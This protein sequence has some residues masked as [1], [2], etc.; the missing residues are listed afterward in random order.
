[1]MRLDSQ[2]PGDAPA[3]A[4]NLHKNVLLLDALTKLCTMSVNILIIIGLIDYGTSQYC[5]QSFLLDAG[6]QV[7]QPEGLNALLRW[8]RVRDLKRSEKN[9]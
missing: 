9:S 1:M 5:F 8:H 6:S 7:F 3:T 2:Y 4:L